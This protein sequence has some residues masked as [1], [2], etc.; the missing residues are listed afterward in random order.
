MISSKRIADA[1]WGPVE[2]NPGFVEGHTWEGG[3]VA[4]AGGIAIIH[5]ILERDLLRNSRE[6]GARLQAGFERLAKKHGVIGDIRGKGLFQAIEFVS[7]VSTKSQFP[8]KPGFGV[9]VGKR[10]LDQGLLCRFDPHWIAFGPALIVTAEQIDEMV[11]ILDRSIGE[12]LA[13]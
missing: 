8:A 2:T 10:A 12:T 6:Q 7:D 1:F 11:A 5:E 13:E 3:P 4:C 9:R